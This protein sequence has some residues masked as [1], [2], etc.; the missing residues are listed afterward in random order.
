MMGFKKGIT[1]LTLKF[2][3]GRIRDKRAIDSS[4]IVTP[5]NKGTD[6]LNRE[7]MTEILEDTPSNLPLI[8]F[9]NYSGNA[10]VFAINDSSD[11]DELCQQETR[12]TVAPNYDTRSNNNN[13][14]ACFPGIS[15]GDTPTNDPNDP[16]N[17]PPTD[18]LTGPTAR[19]SNNPDNNPSKKGFHAPRKL[20]LQNFSTSGQIRGKDGHNK[21]AL[22]ARPSSNLASLKCA[23]KPS[24]DGPPALCI[25]VVAFHHQ[26]GPIVE[27][28]H[29]PNVLGLP[30]PPTDTDPPPSSLASSSSQVNDATL[31]TYDIWNRAPRGENGWREDVRSV[32]DLLAFLAIPDGAHNSEEDFVFFTLPARSGRLLYGTSCYRAISAD[33]LEHRSEDV[34]RSS[35]QKAVCVVAQVPFF[36][37]LHVCLHAATTAYFQQRD[38]RNTGI[39]EALYAQLNAR[40]FENLQYNE[41]FLNV[42]GVNEPLPLS[43]KPAK[44]LSLVKAVLL[45]CK[46]LMYSVSAAMA[47]SSVLALLSFIPG[48]SAL[49]FASDGFGVKLHK[50]SEMGYPLVVYNDMCGCYPYLSLQLLSSLL[51]QKGFIVGTTNQLMLQQSVLDVDVLIDLDRSRVRILKKGGVQDALRLTTND[52]KFINNRINTLLPLDKNTHTHTHTHTHTPTMEGS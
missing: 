48:A 18:P 4:Q 41:L 16:Y 14:G 23:Y 27:F 51:Q 13:M 15:V 10:T 35:V 6:I 11:D 9:S 34:T 43:L 1:N 5:D 32:K 42:Q 24:I 37:C 31:Q 28:S 25:V 49:G 33:S 19:T 40:P 45:E 50:W 39:L 47:S 2:N 29:P 30:L 3:G 17:T 12:S 52:F 26:H 38:F 46:I 8:D 21:G 22:G 7:G 36:G 20:P 44:L